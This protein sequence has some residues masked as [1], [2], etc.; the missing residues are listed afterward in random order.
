MDC[1]VLESLVTVDHKLVRWEHESAVHALDAGGARAGVQFRDKQAF[2][3]TETFMVDFEAL[4]GSLQ[5]QG[6]QLLVAVRRVSTAV[7]E[8]VAE[9]LSI[10]L[11]DQPAGRSREGQD[12]HHFEDLQLVRRAPG[13]VDVQVVAHRVNLLEGKISQD[14]VEDLRQAE[15]LLAADHE[16]GDG[17]PLQDRLAPLRGAVGRDEKWTG[18]YWRC[19]GRQG[20]H[21]VCGFSIFTEE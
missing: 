16:A 18:H 3:P 9:A 4:L 20:E 7:D 8:S 10:R 12:T 2:T 17:L 21:H 6:A 15:T 19:L 13:A 11:S 14:A 1:P 5:L